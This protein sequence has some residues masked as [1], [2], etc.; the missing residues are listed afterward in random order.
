MHIRETGA[1][2]FEEAQ[3]HRFSFGQHQTVA[4]IQPRLLQFIQATSGNFRVGILH[5]RH[6]T[7][8][9]SGD[10]RIGTGRRAAVVATG[11]QR[12]ISGGTARLFTRHA[13]RM[14]FRMRFTGA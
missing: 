5:R 14:N 8:Y 3:I 1:H 6:H 9:A 2:P 12:D 7:G 11:F 13:Q 4:H 10:Q